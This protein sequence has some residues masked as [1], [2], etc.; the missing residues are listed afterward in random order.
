MDH[1]HLDL[2]R[3]LL[4]HGANA[5]ARNTILS[6][7]TALHNAAWNGDLDMV[8]L[9]VEQGANLHARDG[10]HHNTPRGWARTAASITNNPACMDVAAW[11]E[12]QGG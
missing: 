11:L 2:V 5:N 12:T 6:R 10:E 1:R 8:Q 4:S 7:Q 9:L 3:W